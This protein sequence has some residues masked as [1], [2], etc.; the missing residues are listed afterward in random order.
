MGHWHGR[1]ILRVGLQGGL[2]CLSLRHFNLDVGEQD[3]GRKIRA[4]S[5]QER[6]QHDT[7]GNDEIDGDGAFEPLSRF[8]LQSLDTAAA[9]QYSMPVFDA[10]AQ[11][12]PVQAFLGL[13]YRGDLAGCQQEPLQRLGVGGRRWFEYMDHCELDGLLAGPVRRRAELDLAVAQIDVRGT[14]LVAGAR[15]AFLGL[16]ALARHA[17]AKLALDRALP[18]ELEEVEFLAGGTVSQPCSEP[19]K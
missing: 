4:L 17:D 7:P 10:P 16:S 3:L 1:C 8:V 2:V 19:I 18:D 9:F 15:F 11:A 12:I 6:H 5:A 13:F 14:L